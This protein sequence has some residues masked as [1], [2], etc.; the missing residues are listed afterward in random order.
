MCSSRC[1]DE[2]PRLASPSLH[3][4]S[5][6]HGIGLISWM[7]SGIYVLILIQ[8]LERVMNSS[9]CLRCCLPL[10]V[11]V[12]VTSHPSSPVPRTGWSLCC[13]TK[14]FWAP[15]VPHFEMSPHGLNRI[16]HVSDT[17][18][19]CTFTSEGKGKP[20]PC[21]KS[22]FSPVSQMTVFWEKLILK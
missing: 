10:T 9:C 3:P 17:I 4:K 12:Q 8:N 1:E 16:L 11:P 15:F 6:L 19:T 5:C 22:V 13:H 14:V 18:C 7:V 2:A 21:I 20:K